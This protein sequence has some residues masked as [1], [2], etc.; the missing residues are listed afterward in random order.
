MQAVSTTGS[1][2]TLGSLAITSGSTILFFCDNNNYHDDVICLQG[3]RDR[4]ISLI[5]KKLHKHFALQ[6]FCQN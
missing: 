6:L 1:L 5:T 2:H 4:G 3:E